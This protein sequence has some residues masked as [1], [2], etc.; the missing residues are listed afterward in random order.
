LEPCIA[1][2]VFER[3]PS[4]ATFEAFID[5]AGGSGTDAMTMC[6]RHRQDD[7]IVIDALRS[8]QPP[9]SPRAV[10]EEFSTLLATYKLCRV[11]GDRF[12]GEFVR[13][14]FRDKGIGFELAE[15]SKS[16]LYR[17]LVPLINSQRISILDD[18]RAI[19]QLLGLERRVSRGTGKDLIDHASGANAHDDSANAISG[20]ASILA[21]ESHY[22]RNSM[23]LVAGP[24][25]EIPADSIPVITPGLR[26]FN[27]F[28]GG[29]PWFR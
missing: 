5:P 18:M 24:D 10:V 11:T 4:D 19:N 20:C 16:D 6:I 3:G 7:L 28:F 9:F 13:E 23:A 27:P 29:P 26:L 15:K 25:D 2:G 21:G 14:P 8:R 22:W 12:G 1:A 17:D